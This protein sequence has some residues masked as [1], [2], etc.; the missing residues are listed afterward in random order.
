MLLVVASGFAAL[1]V[2]GS[3]LSRPVDLVLFLFAL[4]LTGGAANAL[5]QYFEAAIDARMTRTASRRPLP[6]GKIPA[7]QALGF[8][9]SIGVMGVAIMAVFFNVLTAVLAAGT[10]VFYG[11]I[12]TLILKPSTSQNIVIGGIAGAMAPVGAW[13]AATN[14]TALTPWLIFMLIFFWTPPHFWALA[15]CFK[16]DYVR[17]GLPML[18]VVKGDQSTLN[19]MFLYSVVLAAVSVALL[20]VEFGWIHFVAA[21]ALNAL[22]LYKVAMARKNGTHKSIWSVFKFSILYLFGLLIALTADVFV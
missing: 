10:I 22:F 5:N 9:I 13:A 2:E 11:L 16:D 17:T 1:A 19:Q 6:L 20:V 8:S 7:S 14:T 4:F 21:V 15:I 12:Y 3:M 18:P